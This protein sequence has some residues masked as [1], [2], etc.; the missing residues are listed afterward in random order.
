MKSIF[1]FILLVLV[2]QGFAQHSSTYV[3]DLRTSRATVTDADGMS[4]TI[5][6]NSMSDHPDGVFIKRDGR[7]LVFADSTKVL[8]RM[9]RKNNREFVL[10][11]GRVF[12]LLPKNTECQ[13]IEYKVDGYIVASATFSFKTRRQVIVELTTENPDLAPVLLFSTLSHIRS[14]QSTEAENIINIFTMSLIM[15]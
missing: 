4:F 14:M 7:E 8:G 2:F 1:T 3:V 12:S 6:R 5:G 13:R 10:Y 15:M 9:S 11:D